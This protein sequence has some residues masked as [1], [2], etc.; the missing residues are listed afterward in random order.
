MSAE[1][2][3][4]F[5]TGHSR[6]RGPSAYTECSWRCCRLDGAAA[7]HKTCYGGQRA[8]GTL[9]GG[10][11]SLVCVLAEVSL[12]EH[13]IPD[14]FGGNEYFMGICCMR[15][16]A[17]A[18]DIARRWCTKGTLTDQTGW[19]I[20]WRSTALQH[21]DLQACCSAQEVHRVSR[22]Y[23]GNIPSSAA[24]PPHPSSS[25]WQVC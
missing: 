14:A 20:H 17:L 10:S 9:Q 13:R 2:V 11:G 1:C 16:M 8:F 3:P 25:C 22:N 12:V 4:S 24:G 5:E 7:E 19:G 6:R 18:F 21:G 15:R 23:S